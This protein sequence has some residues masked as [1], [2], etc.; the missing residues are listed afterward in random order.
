MLF[1]FISLVYG[2]VEKLIEEAKKVKGDQEDLLEEKDSDLTPPPST[3]SQ[4]GHE[5]V[6]REV[7]D[8]V[9]FAVEKEL[10]VSTCIYCIPCTI[11]PR[12]HL[13]QSLNLGT[14][15]PKYHLT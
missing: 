3:L 5:D 7:A 10:N 6:M 1:C 9:I 4:I 8:Y 12:Y 2:E 11:K 13:T 15:K 14:I